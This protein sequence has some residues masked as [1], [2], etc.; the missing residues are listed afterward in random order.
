MSAI[1]RRFFEGVLRILFRAYRLALESATSEFGS[2]PEAIYLS[3]HLRRALIEKQVR[4][5]AEGM[6]GLEGTIA[7]RFGSAHT[8]FATHGFL[9]TLVYVR[10]PDA[11]I[12]PAA[13]RRNYAESNLSLFDSPAEPSDD[14]YGI[15]IHG[16][17]GEKGKPPQQPSFARLVFPDAAVKSYH[18]DYV[19]LF[20]EFA[21]TVDSVRNEHS[22]PV[23]LV[24]DE[25]GFE[26]IKRQKERDRA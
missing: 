18:H 6:S 9:F 24:P 3:P 8:L 4:S 23:E 7:G 13:Y 21:Q 12:R 10:H 2:G 25:V 16:G 11:P 1:P 20:R 22:T 17:V 26:L 15:L 14:I 5:L 19:D